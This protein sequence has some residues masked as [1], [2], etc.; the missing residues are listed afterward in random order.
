MFNFENINK[1]TEAQ[2]EDLIQKV[3]KL[4]GDNYTCEDLKRDL[5]NI[6]NE[7]KDKKEPQIIENITH[8]E[9][10]KNAMGK[11]NKECSNSE[12]NNQSS[13][14]NQILRELESE[15]M[16]RKGDSKLDISQNAQK[17]ME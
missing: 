16:E 2:R 15:D 4:G 12:M 8:I 17:N 1:S 11:D 9:Q 10:R 5:M 13:I 6:E 7:D 3:L 14:I